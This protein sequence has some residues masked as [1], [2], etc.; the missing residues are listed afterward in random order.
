MPSLIEAIRTLGGFCQSSD[1][2]MYSASNFDEGSRLTFIE[3]AQ[4]P[5]SWSDFTDLVLRKD[6]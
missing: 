6:G 5:L 3:F 1:N 4:E 2:E